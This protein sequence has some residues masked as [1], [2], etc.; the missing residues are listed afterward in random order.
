[1]SLISPFLG[2]P[3]SPQPSTPALSPTCSCMP[4]PPPP[5]SCI[6]P[7][8]PPTHLQLCGGEV[9]RLLQVCQD[10]ALPRLAWGCG[11]GVE[12]EKTQLGINVRDRIIQDG[13]GTS[14]AWSCQALP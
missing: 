13:K 12:Q 9:C 7:P 10:L 2:Q 3:P 4:C 1:M 8:H 6:P 5:P 11:E 14:R